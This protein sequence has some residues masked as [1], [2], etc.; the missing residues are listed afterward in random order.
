MAARICHPSALLRDRNESGFSTVKSGTASAAPADARRPAASRVALR[1]MSKWIRSRGGAQ[2]DSPASARQC[3][4][5]DAEPVR[6]AND[7]SKIA[8]VDLNAVLVEA[9]YIAHGNILQYYGGT[10][11]PGTAIHP[12]CN[13]RLPATPLGELP[14]LR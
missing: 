4:G 2:D 11:R 1:C 8:C 13:R 7:C 14:A 3:D 12:S 5:I 6:G 9:F 10:E